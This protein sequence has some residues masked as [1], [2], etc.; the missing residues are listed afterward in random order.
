MADGK[1]DAKKTDDAKDAASAAGNDEAKNKKK[2]LFMLIGLAVLLVAVSIGGT[3]GAM[4]LLS[5]S[6]SGEE[7]S[8]DSEDEEENSDEEDSHEEGS[9]E[10]HSDEDSG[11]EKKSKKHGKSKDSAKPTLPA[12][13]F[14]LQP[15]FTV[16][17]DVDGKQRYLQT[18]ITLMYRDESVLKV[19]EM[20]MP[21]VRNGIVLSL[22]SQQFP[23]LQTSEGRENLRVEL[24]KTVQDI[25]L[26]EQSLTEEKDGE[27]E[28]KPKSKKKSKNVKA[29]PSVEQV[30]FTQ[31]VLQ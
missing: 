6:D 2:K 1:K 31:F 29:L 27:K 8:S 21:A 25:L 7:H 14:L 13:Y 11:E 20:H 16:N 28:E 5:P 18:E 19:I 9:D 3:I 12:S 24:L 22:S 10:D 15:N 4:K 17:Y 26:K 30:L 23:D